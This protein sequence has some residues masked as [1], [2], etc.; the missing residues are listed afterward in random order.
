[1]LS[2]TTHT[3]SWPALSSFWKGSGS[4][5]ITK[6]LSIRRINQILLEHPAVNH[7]FLYWTRAN[8]I[9]EEFSLSLSVFIFFFLSFWFEVAAEGFHIL[10]ACAVENLIESLISLQ[11]RLAFSTRN[12]ALKFMSPLCVHLSRHREIEPFQWEP[13]PPFP[14][15]ARHRDERRE[16]PSSNSSPFAINF[17]SVTKNRLMARLSLPPTH[18]AQREDEPKGGGR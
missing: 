13:P 3:H 8:C 4:S 16:D 14:S 5:S 11:T 18:Q 6:S 10:T 12:G 7:I 17:Y 15:P 2:W 1:M 9:W